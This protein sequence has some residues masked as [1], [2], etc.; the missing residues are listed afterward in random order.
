MP[1]VHALPDIFHYWSNRYLAPKLET[2]GASHPEAFFLKYMELNRAKARR[3][4]IDSSASA[5]VIVSPSM[6][7]FRSGRSRNATGEHS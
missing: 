4:R 1:T 5:R 3:D 2:F 6:V 7:A